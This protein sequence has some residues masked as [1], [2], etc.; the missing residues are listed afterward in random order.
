MDITYKRNSKYFI[1][2]SK[3][4]PQV[5]DFKNV[6]YVQDRRP[7]KSPGRKCNTTKIFNTASK[8]SPSHLTV[9]KIVTKG[10]QRKLSFEEIINL[11]EIKVH[12]KEQ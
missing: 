5:I 11:P 3:T 7:S 10:I 6:Y 1:K 8:V 2:I 12:L 9:D 4:P